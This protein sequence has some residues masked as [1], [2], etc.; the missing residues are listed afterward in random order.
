MSKNFIPSR[1]DLLKSGGALI[2]SFS[3]AGRPGETLAQEAAA[4][5]PLA[6]TAVDTFLAIDAAG[7]VTVYSGK[8]DLGT[9]VRTAL[10]QIVADELDVPFHR[11]KIVQG[12]TAL[13]PDQGPTFGSLSIQVGGVQIRNAAAM[14]RSALLDL[15]A[16]QLA[17]KPDDLTVSEGTISG[18]GKRVSYGELVGGKAFSLTLDHTKPPKTKDAKDYKIVGT[19]IPRVDIPDKVT[20]KFTYMHDF[21]V[22]GMLHGRVVRPPAIGATLESVDESSINGI[23]G[24]VKIVREGNF[25]GV[26]A[27]NEWT[28]IKA[29][30]QLKASWS[31]WE[32]L[33]DQGKLMEHV[34]ATKV[35]KDETTGNV[36]NAAEAMSKD[37]VKKLAATWRRSR[38]IFAAHQQGCAHEPADPARD[39]PRAD[40]GGIGG[41]ARHAA[42]NGAQG[43]QGRQGAIVAGDADR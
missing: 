32:G 2:V 36:G 5:K 10:A 12:D 41:K 27:E 34:R 14:A 25:L 11:V 28:A 15:A 24:I 4:A 43:S 42:G 29:A 21:R 35:A 40:A 26:V 22:P 8:V 39:R 6:L 1:R 19:S 33:P 18:G 13:T 31:N 20:G 37:G 38:R 16:T 17:V 30:A 3:F 9:G 23:A 7:M